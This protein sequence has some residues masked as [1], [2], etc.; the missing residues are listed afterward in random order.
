MEEAWLIVRKHGV[1]N[2]L[3]GRDFKLEVLSAESLINNY[4]YRRQRNFSKLW[5]IS[6]MLMQKCV[7]ISNLHLCVQF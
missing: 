4:N 1:G 2:S 6:M 5:S 7:H 3:N